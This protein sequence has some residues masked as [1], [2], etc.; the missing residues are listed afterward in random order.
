MM[1]QQREYKQSLQ[2]LCAEKQEIDSFIFQISLFFIY[3][4]IFKF[5]CTEPLIG[6]IV[7]AEISREE[8]TKRLEALCTALA[9]IENISRFIHHKQIVKQ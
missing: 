1:I 6:S 9:V 7:R 4:F 8:R 5:D 2:V 3:L